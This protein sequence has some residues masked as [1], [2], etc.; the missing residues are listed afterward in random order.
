[1]KI[2]LFCAKSKCYCND[3]PVTVA[4]LSKI[5]DTLV[6]IHGQNEHQTLLKPQNQLNMADSYGDLQQQREKIALS[7]KQYQSLLEEIS[8]LRLSQQER[9]Q[10]IDIY[11]FQVKEIDAADLKPNSEEEI[12]RI[13]PQLKN[14]E[15]LIKLLGDAYYMLE[16]ED[17][18]VLTRLFKIN[19]IIE[20]VNSISDGAFGANAQLESITAQLKEV[21]SSI[22]KYR[23]NLNMDPKELDKLLEKKDLILKLKRKYGATVEEVLAYREKTAA[24]LSKLENSSESINELEKKINVLEKS[25]LKQCEALSVERKNVCL[26]LQ[27]LV[28]KEIREK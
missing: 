10:K 3:Q 2:C 23:D 1:M 14:S 17:S 28:E 25:L 27:K 11:K 16:E 21:A 19:Q 15:K 24:E 26:K 18:S 8:N 9:D 22:E 20:N 6:D 4:F 7:N 12:D 13:L 5:G